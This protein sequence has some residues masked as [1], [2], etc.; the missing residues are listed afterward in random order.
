VGDIIAANHEITTVEYEFESV[1]LQLTKGDCPRLDVG[2][3]LLLRDVRFVIND[4]NKL[5]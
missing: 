1:S 4:A 2:G 5:F 3:I